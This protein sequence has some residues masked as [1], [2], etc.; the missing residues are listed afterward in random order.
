VASAFDR[1]KLVTSIAP[2]NIE[3]QQRAVA[4]W[5]QLGFSVTSLNTAAEAEQLRP[6][7]EGVEFSTVS[8]D[9]R[10]ECGR[11]LVY[12]N[13]VFAFLR[14]SGTPV[15]G[16]INSDIHL[17]GTLATRDFVIDQARG[18]MV[19]A[20][21]SDVDSLDQVAGEVYVHGFDLFLFDSQ[22]LDFLPVTRFCL[23][24]PW[25]DYWFPYFLSLRSPK[26][27]PVKL[28]AFPF[29]V[30]IRHA[31]NW[32]TD[33]FEKYGMHFLECMDPQVHKALRDQSPDKRWDSISVYSAQ[34]RMAILHRSKWL[35]YL[36][37]GR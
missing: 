20:S 34:V 33:Y 6:Q 16:L 24:Q 4:S 36:P 8:R 9:A 25:W 2:R 37:P 27:Y 1:I 12:L 10:A 21:R 17:R 5:L 19:I 14:A 32:S 29:A 18:S 15:C 7:F 26:P 3:N 30:H 23:G 22:I 35:S 28:L 13:D 11:P 31:N